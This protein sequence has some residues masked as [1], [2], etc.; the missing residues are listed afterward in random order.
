M[1]LSPNQVVLL[2][3]FHPPAAEGPGVSEFGQ[4]EDALRAPGVGLEDSAEPVLA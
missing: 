3:L 2:G 4:W 1:Q